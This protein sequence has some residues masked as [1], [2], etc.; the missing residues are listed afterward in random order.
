MLRKITLTLAIAATAA[1][2]LVPTAGAASPRGGDAIAGARCV[3]DGVRFLLDERPARRRRAAADR[4]RRDRLR[5][6]R[7]RGCDQH[8]PARWL[9]PAARRRHPASLHEPGALRLVQLV[10]DER[11]EARRRRGRE[12]RLPAPK[13]RGFRR[14]GGQSPLRRSGWKR[15]TTAIPGQSAAP[16]S[17]AATMP[18]FQ[19]RR[20]RRRKDAGRR[21]VREVDGRA[22]EPPAPP[23]ERGAEQADVGVRRAEETAQS[24]LGGGPCGRRRRAGERGAQIVVSRS[25]SRPRRARR[26]T[27]SRAARST[28]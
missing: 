26:P 28:P 4:L 12:R 14:S 15:S 3:Q 11:A 8:E 19:P 6:R 27:R 24:G 16:S 23:R 5:L 9:V 21:A 17:C 7:H 18:D 10:A 13:T 1:V 22:G 2:A 20:P 25:D